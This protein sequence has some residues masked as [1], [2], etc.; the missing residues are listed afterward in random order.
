M[1]A[2]REA[3]IH[4]AIW[5]DP[6]TEDLASPGEVF[7]CVVAKHS[8]MEEVFRVLNSL[9]K[10]GLVERYALGGAV[11]AAFYMEPVT[12]YDVDVLVILPPS[13]SPLVTLSPI[14][15]RLT[16][17]GHQVQAEH[18]LV[19]GQPMQFLPA[20]NSLVE[21]AVLEA[22]EFRYGTT[23]VRVPRPEHLAAIMLQT[24]RRKDQIRLSMFVDEVALDLAHFGDI[25]ARHEL[26]ARW[27]EFRS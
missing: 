22:V 13:E 16:A 4:A 2:R 24:H 25:L 8:I 7:S 3:A 17:M 11:A 5:R 26:A 14:Y 19:E 1:I 23:P 21:E 27:E 9:E 20:Y 12:T 10:A 6:P 18:I 15:D